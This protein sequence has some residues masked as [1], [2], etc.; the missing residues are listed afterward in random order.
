MQGEKGFIGS[1]SVYLF[2]NILNAAIPFILLPVLTRYLSPE[3]YGEVA[4]FQ[5]LLG[6]L[7]AFVGATFVGAANRKY[8]DANLSKHDLAEFIGSCIQLILIS[9]CIVFLIIYFSQDQFSKWLSLKPRHLLLA[10]V[11]SVATGIVTLRLGQWQV[12]KD[13]AK[14]GVLQVSQSLFNM[15]LSLL[16]VVVLLK[17]ADGRI[18]AQIIISIIFVLV[19]LVYLKKDGLL[20]FLTW[21]KDYLGEV[22]KF[23]VPLIPHISGGFLLNS[24]DRLVI[25]QEIGLGEA[26]V[27]MVA[28]QLTAAIGIIFDAI[29][30]AYVPWLFE[31]LKADIHKVKQKIVKLTYLWFVVIF[32]GV[33]L[34]FVI[35]P[36]VV[37]FIAGEKY[38]EAGDVI[39]WLVLGQGFQGMYLMVTNYIF[40][41]K[42]TGMLSFASIGSGLLNLLLLL[43]FIRGLGLQGAAIAFA[44][45][46]GVRFIL[47]WLIAQRRHPMPWFSFI[48]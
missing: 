12:R 38:S 36:K 28:V 10:V 34:S 13:A 40:F 7:G 45:S 23:G 41:S 16:L 1:A 29:N 8:Y 33:A 24:V 5:T 17:G 43:I 4:M 39:G 27:Y 25:N 20:K 26:G 47:T 18:N 44:V 30:K 35:G 32:F 46:M 37:V 31:K 48:S 14:F 19:A 42:R 6:A 15:L 2:S 3:E 11:V 22:L 21:R 9:A